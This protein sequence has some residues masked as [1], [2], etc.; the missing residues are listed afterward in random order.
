VLLALDVGN[1]NIVLAVFEGSGDEARL[2]GD[3]R[4]RTDR[5]RTVDEHGMLVKDLLSHRGLSLRDVSAVAV[6]SVVPTMTGT[7]T[8]MA[9]RY[10]GVE[11]FVVGPDT[12]TGIQVHCEPRSDIGADRICNSVGA[13]AKYG[14]PAIVVDYGTATT[15]DAVG[16][17]GD[18]MGGAICPGIGISMDALFRQAARLFRV[19]VVEPPRAIGTN[20]VHAM[21]SG[22]VY[23]YAG[24]TDALVDR[25]RAELGGSARV[26]AT[27]GLAELIASV[28]RTIEA[29]DQL[30]LLEGLRLLWERNC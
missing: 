4:I 29:V 5:D 13:F 22:L 24:Q 12:D 15:F 20:T 18:Y 8:A 3:W 25:I 11:A 21:Q 17:N 30:V 10:F 27:G 16:A 28:S 7:L 14:G 23:G 26:I 6:S 19:E 1:T 9:D 2:A